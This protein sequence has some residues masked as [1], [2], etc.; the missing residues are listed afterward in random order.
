VKITKSKDGKYDNNDFNF[1]VPKAG[2]QPQQ[3]SWGG[4]GF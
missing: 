4:Q 2:Q 3:R 1:V